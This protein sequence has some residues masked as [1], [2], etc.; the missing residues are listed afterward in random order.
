[1]TLPTQGSAHARDL[2]S[3]VHPD[4]RRFDRVKFTSSTGH[5]YSSASNWEFVRNFRVYQVSL[6]N[7]RLMPREVQLL[8]AT[9]ESLGI[10]RTSIFP[11]G[12][13]ILG[14]A[15][16]CLTQTQTPSRRRSKPPQGKASQMRAPNGVGT[17]F[18]SCAVTPDC[19]AAWSRQ[20]ALCRLYG[21]L[22]RAHP[23]LNL[24]RLRESQS[25]S[26]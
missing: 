8:R 20:L 2:F 15:L 9:R 18:R 11:L 4:E 6:A 7:G 12:L 25:Q 10:D 17:P 5:D 19:E 1:M 21:G 26:P 3:Q 23:N 22:W 16:E 24:R 14:G 13:D